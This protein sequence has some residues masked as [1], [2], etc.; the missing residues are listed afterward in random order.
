[1]E[2]YNHSTGMGKELWAKRLMKR[3]A[4]TDFYEFSEYCYYS[5][6]LLNVK[7]NNLSPR[8]SEL[9]DLRQDV[10]N[11]TSRSKEDFRVILRYLTDKED[12]LNARITKIRKAIAVLEKSMK[13]GMIRDFQDRYVIRK[14]IE[15]PKNLGEELDNKK[16]GKII[17]SVWKDKKPMMSNNQ[18]IAKFGIDMYGKLVK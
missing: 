4:F 11:D 6:R 16:G 12:K 2:R 1:M 7:L 8:L 15:N 9:E 3:F 5:F 14:M 10:I 13:L 18:I 17:K